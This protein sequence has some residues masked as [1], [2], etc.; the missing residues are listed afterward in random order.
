MK[1]TTRRKMQK[2]LKGD[3]FIVYDKEHTASSDSHISGD[4]SCD[5]YIVYDENGNSWFETDFPI[6]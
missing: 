3:K 6:E 4:A 5:E 1:N 2:L